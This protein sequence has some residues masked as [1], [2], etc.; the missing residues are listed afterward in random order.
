MSRFTG[1]LLWIW[2]I[3]N[4]LRFLRQLQQ[5]TIHRF[6]FA[7]VC[8]I[9]RFQAESRLLGRPCLENALHCRISLRQRIFWWK[10]KCTDLISHRFVGLFRMFRRSKIDASRIIMEWQSSLFRQRWLPSGQKRFLVAMQWK[11]I[12]LSRQHR[13]RWRMRI[14]SRVFRPIALSTF[15][16]HRWKRIKRHRYGVHM[17]LIW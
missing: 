10:A 14:R 15:R 8:S 6:I 7:E 13:P 3:W 16:A 2:R 11:N 12:I 4:G 9:W 1:R 5:S 17:L